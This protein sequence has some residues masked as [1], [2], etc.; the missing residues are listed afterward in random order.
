MAIDRITRDYNVEEIELA[1]RQNREPLLLP[2]FSVHNLRHTFCTRMCENESNIKVIQEI[3]GHSDISMTMD[4]YN[5]A[6][7]DKKKKSFAGLEGKI[8]ILEINQAPSAGGAFLLLNRKEQGKMS[9]IAIYAGHGGTDSG[10]VGQKGE[11]EKDYT[12][13]IS[14]AAINCLKSAGHEIITNRTSDVNRDITADAD[15]ANAENVDCVA[16]IHL[17]SNSGTPAAGSEVFYSITGGE[18][19]DM[20]QAI[21]D[22]IVALGYKSRGIKTKTNSAGK[23][24]FGIIR[25]TKAP[26]VLV[27]VCFIN[28][29]EDMARLDCEAAGR[30]IAQGIMAV[31]GGAEKGT[32]AAQPQDV[33]T[34]NTPVK[35]TSATDKSAGGDT[36]I[37]SIQSA[38]NRR[39]EPGI[40]VDGIYGP[41]TKAALVRGLQTELSKQYG[42]GLASRWDLQV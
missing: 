28:N 39:Y 18:G 5:E 12:L 13:K 31:F 40:S 6:T 25:Q 27:E 38:M 29:P 7:R 2:H 34:E 42:K 33:P 15:R 24:H 41:K 16:E 20:A 17:N 26:A 11:L 30:A 3:M 36:V 23:D 21:L 8:N 14:A 35:E 1:V 10:A 22:R 37:K 19:K 32:A 4:V 9:K